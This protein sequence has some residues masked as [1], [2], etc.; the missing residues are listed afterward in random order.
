MCVWS[1]PCPHMVMFVVQRSIR[2]SF[3]FYTIP[4]ISE[5]LL[6]EGSLREGSGSAPPVSRCGR[7]ASSSPPVLRAAS[8]TVRSRA[9]DD[10]VSPT[11]DDDRLLVEEELRADL[12]EREQ[13]LQL[14]AEYGQRVLAKNE[15][16]EDELAAARQEAAAMQARAEEAE[17]RVRELTSDVSRLEE[18]LQAKQA[19]L[20][21]AEAALEEQRER[22]ADMQREREAE[23]AMVQPPAAGGDRQQ[24]QQQQ[25][26]ADDHGEEALRRAQEEADASAE[27]VQRAIEEEGERRRTAEASAQRLKQR[28]ERTEVNLSEEGARMAAV[29]AERDAVR[30]AAEAEQRQNSDLQVR[31]A[32][33]ERQL[34]LAIQMQAAVHPPGPMGGGES[35]L[36]GGCSLGAELRDAADCVGGAPGGSLGGGGSTVAISAP[37]VGEA[38]GGG[39]GGGGAGGEGA[40]EERTR[41]SVNTREAERRMGAPPPPAAAQ[42][43]TG[44]AGGG[45]EGS[46]KAEALQDMLAAVQAAALR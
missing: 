17:W 25:P 43:S 13:Q 36:E 20:E 11:A 23:G 46:S 39:G 30:A 5:A 12:E 44:G 31:L 18:L 34:K 27:E 3:V 10:G 15:A 9:V 32:E 37:M 38:G 33:M 2:I 16:L 28:L 7:M 26:G 41:S 29:V 19:A 40:L 42:W 35:G 8:S 45:D 14:A 1:C 21:G 4:A 22:H 24:Q 6:F